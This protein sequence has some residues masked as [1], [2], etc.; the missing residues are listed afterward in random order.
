[1][2]IMRKNIF[3][4][5]TKRVIMTK[6]VK[7]IVLLTTIILC[8][9]H[10]SAQRTIPNGDFE[11]WTLHDEG[12]AG[13][14]DYW[15]PDSGWKENFQ[16]IA[17]RFYNSAGYFYRYEESDAN[18][19]ALKLQGSGPSANGFI[20]FRCD[21]VPISLKGQYKFSNTGCDDF[22]IYVYAINSADTISHRQLYEGIVHSSAKSFV[23]PITESFQDFEIDLSDFKDVDIDYFVIMFS[24]HIN[25][26]CTKTLPAIGDVFTN[27]PNGF[28]VV[29]DLELVYELPTPEYLV[30]FK[31]WDGTLL[32]EQNV[33]EG[34]AATPPANPTREGFIFMGWTV[35]FDSVTT[36]LEVIALYRDNTIDGEVVWHQVPNGNFESWTLHEEIGW[37]EEGDYWLPDSGWTESSVNI[38]WRLTNSSGYFYRYE[39]SDANGYALTLKGSRPSANG[40]IRFRCD[41]VPLSLK[42]RYKFSNTGC[43]DFTIYTYAVNSADTLLYSQLYEGVVHSS[44]K[45]FVTP[46]SESF[47]DFEIDLSDF[48]DVDIDYFVIMFK[49][50]ANGSCTK[51]LPSG[52]VTTNDPDGFAVV[53]DLELVYG[54]LSSVG[55]EF[56]MDDLIIYPNPTKERVNLILRKEKV[57]YNIQLDDVSGNMVIEKDIKCGT[58]QLNL[59]DVP[60]GM[61]FLRIR[62]N[63]KQ[64][65]IKIIKQ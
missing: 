37:S 30:E 21:E 17:T 5:N 44:A 51:T 7:L 14:G 57:D 35:D 4:D 15:L 38:A 18:G 16:N 61:Y 8:N 33:L 36:D 28:A 56:L 62:Q 20:R 26:S 11:S 45:N 34:E 59:N 50:S 60:S 12:I 24:V 52:D 9:A 2:Q 6:T 55:K 39:E 1:M 43:D 48:K 54:S 42:G 49:T 63:M 32:K 53:D 64:K 13:C 47:Q 46:V 41:E 31:D 25:R 40:F 58:T 10:V 27:D 19:Y 23:A 3:G 29:D 22:T 65:T